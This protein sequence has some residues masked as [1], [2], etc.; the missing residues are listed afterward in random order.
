MKHL[1]IKSSLSG[2]PATL[3]IF[4][5]QF[6]E[7]CIKRTPSIKRTVAEGPKVISLIDFK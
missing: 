3:E 7:T 4:I 5:L 6:S 1:L 2:K